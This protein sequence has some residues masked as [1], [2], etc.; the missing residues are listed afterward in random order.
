MVQY[1]EQFKL[2][3]V[4][5]YLRGGASY[6]EVA[7]A[8]GVEFSQLR[9]WVASYEM[10][11][12]SGL[13]RKNAGNY[14]ASL[15][16]EVLARGRSEGLSDRQLAAL[17]DIRS[18]SQIRIWRSQY[19]ESGA[20][21]LLPQRRHRRSMPPTPPPEPSHEPDEKRPPQ[22]LL[23]ELAYLRAENAYLKKVKALIEAERTEALGKKR[24]WSN[25]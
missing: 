14:D 16:L 2:K 1:N 7:M 17:Y 12:R 19:D 23:E 22:E 11:G 4:Q 8:H 9:R 3:A 5:Q 18:A 21:A 10:H 6:R 13:T 15:K 24:N 25:D 20:S